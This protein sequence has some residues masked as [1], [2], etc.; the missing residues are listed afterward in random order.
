LTS[1]EIDAILLSLSAALPLEPAGR[2]RSRCAASQ[3]TA[4][5]CAH[6]GATW[7]YNA[8]AGV[9]ELRNDARNR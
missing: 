9:A 5:S 8:P 1:G 3:R 6:S 4:R 7:P 2:R